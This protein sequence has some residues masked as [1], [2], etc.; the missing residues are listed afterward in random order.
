V[1]AGVF[2]AF[3]AHST[4]V[5]SEYCSETVIQSNRLE[6]GQMVRVQQGKLRV[7]VYRRSEIEIAKAKK[8]VG[9]S[10]DERYPSWWPKDK[11]PLNYFSVAER[12]VVPEYF[13]FW[14]RS[15]INGAI[16]T[17]INSE[18]YDESEDLSYLGDKWQSG[19][20]DYEN[21]VYYDTTGRPVKWGAKSKGL[22]LSKLPLLIPNHEYDKKT[23]NIRLLCQ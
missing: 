11:Y 22:E 10:F 7:N 21:Q 5:S 3:I 16:I 17:L 14:D 4:P 13:V 2:V 8:H 15:P 9:G 6:A 23:G 20:I 1:L 18:W 19:L 12:S